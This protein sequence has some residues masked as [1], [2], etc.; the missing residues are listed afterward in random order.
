M[1]DN[2]AIG[3]TAAQYLLRR[4]HRRLAY[5]GTGASWSLEIRSLSFAHAAAEA[6][7]D[8]QII[9]TIEEPGADFW[10]R[11]G[12]SG[13]ARSIAQRLAALKHRPTG[14]FIA[15][16]RLVPLVD[17]ALRLQ[18]HRHN[19]IGINGD[20]IKGDG[21]QHG[22]AQPGANGDRSDNHVDIISCNNERSHFAGLESIPATIDIRADSIGRLGVERLIW[23]LRNPD[24]P[25]RI[26]CMVEP[27]MVEG[28]K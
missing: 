26:R 23:R 6:G 4:G 25:E 18:G 22:S 21:A 28:E 14:L 15:E 16:D 24:A 2:S 19:G 27:T 13:A 5:L 12:L 1:P 3:A 17:A 9:Q 10:Q 20:G 11:D 8:V 7:A